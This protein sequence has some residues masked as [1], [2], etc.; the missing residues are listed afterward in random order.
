MPSLPHTIYGYCTK[1][2]DSAYT[3]IV[4]LTNQ[5]INQT[6][7]MTCDSQ[8]RYLF[9]LANMSDYSDEDILL[10][11]VEGYSK[12]AFLIRN[13]AFEDSS[14]ETIEPFDGQR[15][16]TATLTMNFRVSNAVSRDKTRVEVFRQIRN[17]LSDDPP[18]YT[19]K[20]E[21]TRTYSVFSAF[22]EVTP[23]FPC[24][25]VNPIEK[26]TTK[27]G[28]SKRPNTTMPGEIEIDFYEKTKY[29]KNAIDLA[30]DYVET[31]LFNNWTTESLT[32]DT[33][34]GSQQ[35]DIQGLE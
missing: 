21:S 4:W 9:D 25:V 20:D 2:D 22:P 1:A 3:G 19:V 6:V 27:L 30:R 35:Q 29:G 32:V 12:P 15:L 13:D 8:G 23:V 26:G 18:S 7:S 28:V 5:N 16:N 14:I 10:M 17:L 24:I 31:R 33:S 11:A 34:T